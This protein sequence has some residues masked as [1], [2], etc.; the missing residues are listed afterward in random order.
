MA[1]HSM[2]DSSESFP[3]RAISSGMYLGSLLADATHH[4]KLIFRN[5]S[6]GGVIN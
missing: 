4:E 6:P 2:C 3:Q 5:K 1:D